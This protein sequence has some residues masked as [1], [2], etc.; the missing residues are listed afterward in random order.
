VA[1][2]ITNEANMI[3]VLVRFRYESGFS[4]ER[5]R[6][7]AAAARAKFEGMPGL[8]SKAFTIDPANRE[9]LNFYVWE[10]EEAAKAFFSQQL[11][12]RVAELYGVRPTVHFVEVAA[13]VDNR[14][15]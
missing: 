14:A 13:L 5:V 1:F 12:D 9:A 2:G 15:S 10:S 3:G 11:I 8:R 4:E 7:V 6:Q